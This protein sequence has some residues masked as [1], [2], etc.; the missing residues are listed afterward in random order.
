VVFRGL[1]GGVEGIYAGSGG[2][3]Q[4]I[5]TAG[6][7]FTQFSGAPVVNAAGTIALTATRADGGRQVIMWQNGQVW[8]IASTGGT[9]TDF[10]GGLVSLNAAGDLAFTV[11]TNSG[12]SVTRVSS[13]GTTVVASSAG[14]G[15]EQ[16]GGPSLSDNGAVVFWGERSSPPPNL[17]EQRILS[18][19][20]ASVNVVGGGPV[21]ALDSDWGK[22]PAVN[23]V[24]QVLFTR[25]D[26]TLYLGDANGS[27]PR[28]LGTGLSAS[29][30]DLGGVAVL[31]GGSIY[32]L[33]PGGVDLVYRSGDPLLGSTVRD[34]Y[35]SR[36]ALNDAGQV[37]FAADLADGRSV[38]MRAD[39]V[40]EPAAGLAVAV[41]LGALLT[42]RRRR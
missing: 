7:Q 37:A 33:R 23:A 12:T 4:P 9:V 2:P 6:S 16:L 40:P 24:G 8:P 25:E 28:P 17:H 11:V 15:Y 3:V 5:V 41:G 13:A 35:F 19:V 36:D 20:G 1:I 27:G 22:Y 26:G 10:A 18:A 42:R 31:G 32:V 39:P 38:V 14:L 34:I 29:L 30:N 21:D